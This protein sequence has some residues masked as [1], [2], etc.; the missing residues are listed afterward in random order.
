MR[1]HILWLM[2]VEHD[3]KL[4]DSHSESVLLEPQDPVRFVWDKTIKQSVHNA[5]M[6]ARVLA[7][8]KSKRRLYKHVPDK[9]FGKKTL[10]AAFDQSFT[11]FRHKFKAQRDE[12]AAMTYKKRED[13]KTLKA[14]RISRRKIVCFRNIFSS[15]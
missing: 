3:K 15:C 13:A 9:D 2:E 14:R 8:L 12:L 6:K 10:D 11:T 5:R 7:D 4:P 1:A